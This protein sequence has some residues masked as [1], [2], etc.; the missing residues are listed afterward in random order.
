MPLLKAHT[1]TM[2]S[3]QGIN[4]GPTDEGEPDNPM[5]NI[6][7]DPGTRCFEFT[8]PGLF[9]SLIGRITTLGDPLDLMTSSI[10]FVRP[11]MT[12]ERIR[13]ITKKKDRS[14]DQKV[15]LRTLCESHL[16]AREL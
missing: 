11:N 1:K 15:Q 13:W 16:D 10:H 2:H 7:A 5:Q 9:D 4:V 3:C 14:A 12:E 8:L 6:V